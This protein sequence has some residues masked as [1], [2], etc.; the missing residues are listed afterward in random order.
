MTA[1]I[2]KKGKIARAQVTQTTLEHHPRIPFIARKIG[3][4]GGFLGTD[5]FSLEFEKGATYSEG[6]SVGLIEAS[7]LVDA[8]S[9]PAESD[10]GAP[11][12]FNVVRIIEAAVRAKSEAP[13]ARK[14]AAHAVIAFFADAVLFAA[15]HGQ[16]DRYFSSRIEKNERW[17]EIE[18][19]RRAR[20]I[21]RSIAARAAKREA[22]KEGGAA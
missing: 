8:L 1:S 22:R 5:Y 13:E 14:G 17:I 15:K 2:S 4:R 20:Q 12:H 11:D 3:P 9:N 18:K 6:N 16:F 19:D 10:A 21:Q 7:G